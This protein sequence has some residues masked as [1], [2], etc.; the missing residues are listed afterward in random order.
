MLAGRSQVGVHLLEDAPLLVRF[1]PI[2]FE[3]GSLLF[4]IR[5]EVARTGTP[6]TAG[7]RFA[8]AKLPADGVARKAR[9][10]GYLS[11]GSSHHAMPDVQCLMTLA[12]PRPVT[13]ARV[14]NVESLKRLILAFC[15][16]GTLSHITTEMDYI[17]NEPASMTYVSIPQLV[18]N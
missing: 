1:G 14:T 13:P 3:P 4:C 17:L 2:A 5:I 11:T 6:R 9:A 10:L 7:R 8:L 12:S 15:D 18:A 16:V